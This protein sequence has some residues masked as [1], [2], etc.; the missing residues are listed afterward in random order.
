MT[1]KTV[2]AEIGANVVNTYYEMPDDQVTIAI[3]LADSAKYVTFEIGVA[4]GIVH[5]VSATFDLAELVATLGNL[6]DEAAAG[7][8][9]VDQ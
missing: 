6:V 2:P 8:P 3:T 4:L 9:D 5:Q 7:I 1:S